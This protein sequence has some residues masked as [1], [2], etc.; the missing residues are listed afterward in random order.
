MI[1]A[2]TWKY[3]KNLI[4]SERSNIFKDSIEGAVLKWQSNR[5]GRPLSPQEIHQKIFECQ[6]TSTKQLL[7]AGGGPSIKMPEAKHTTKIIMNE[8][9][10]KK[11]IRSSVF[12]VPY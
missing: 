1:H 8:D 11:N 2:T 10:L 6:A 3:V 5:K 12:V 4:L 7:N 9:H